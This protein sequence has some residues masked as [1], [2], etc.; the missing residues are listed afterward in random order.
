MITYKSV[1]KHKKLNM[2]AYDV[3]CTMLIN[4]GK[5]SL[6]IKLP[7]TLGVKFKNLPQNEVLIYIHESEKTN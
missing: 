5:I 2:W 1:L 4:N 3:Q 7:L 6:S